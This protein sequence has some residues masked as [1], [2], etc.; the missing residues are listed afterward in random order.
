[1]RFGTEMTSDGKF[2]ELDVQSKGSQVQA[3][4]E[5]TEQ[6][7]IA[8]QLEIEKQKAEMRDKTVKYIMYGA[9]AVFAI[10]AFK[11]K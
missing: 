7:A 6:A 11:K 1:M 9:A 10:W 3:D 4:R 8:A 2:Y 5:A